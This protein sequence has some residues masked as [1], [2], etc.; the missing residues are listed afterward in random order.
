[1]SSYGQTVRGGGAGVHDV[2]TIRADGVGVHTGVHTG[3]HDGHIVRGGGGGSATLS[4]LESLLA[5]RFPSRGIH[6]EGNQA[7]AGPDESTRSLLGM[8]P[9]SLNPTP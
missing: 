6:L 8:Y 2:Q 7:S 9:E 4:N 5:T 3:V 1:M